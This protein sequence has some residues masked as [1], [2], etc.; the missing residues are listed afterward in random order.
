MYLDQKNDAAAWLKIPF[1]K[2]A[3]SYFVAEG[4]YKFDC[5]RIFTSSLNP[6]IFSQIKQMSG[7]DNA[8]HT[9]TSSNALQVEIEY[10]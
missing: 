1:G 9:A 6:I 4:L 10:N 5:G 2:N 3:D 7:A 8:V